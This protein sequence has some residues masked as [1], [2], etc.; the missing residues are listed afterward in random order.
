LNDA[1]PGMRSLTAS[2]DL[3]IGYVKQ[4]LVAPLRGAWRWLGFGLLA[5]FFV[6][7]ASFL[8]LLGTLRLLQSGSLPFDG[9]WSWVPYV[10]VLVLAIAM[11]ILSVSRISKPTLN[12][13]QRRGR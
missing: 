4:E 13:G 3:L 7:V 2:F 11:V 9:G 10:V 6:V 12:G 5:A 1:V 8:F